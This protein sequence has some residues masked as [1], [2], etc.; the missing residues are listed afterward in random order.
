[1]KHATDPLCPVFVL[2]EE[3]EAVATWVPPLLEQME[4]QQT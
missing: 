1:V 4:R 3:N 2:G